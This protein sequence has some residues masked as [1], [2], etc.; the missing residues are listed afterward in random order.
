MQLFVADRQSIVAGEWLT[1]AVIDAA[2]VLLKEHFPEMGGLQRTTLGHT[3]TY[4]VER[5]EF[6]MCKLSTSGEI[7][8]LL[9][10]ILG[11]N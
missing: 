7:T 9:F 1:D 2:Q 10:Q 3:L 6:D 5:G 4:A 8:G 11:A